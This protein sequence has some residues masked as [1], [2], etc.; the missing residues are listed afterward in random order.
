MSPAVCLRDELCARVEERVLV[1]SPAR[2]RAKAGVCR[3][4]SRGGGARRSSC[5]Q[6]APHCSTSTASRRGK[7]PRA[8][9]QVPLKSGGSPVITRPRA[10]TTI[11][12]N[13][14]PMGSIAIWRKKPSPHQPEA[15]VSIRAAMRLRQISAASIIIDFIDSAMSRNTARGARRPERSL[16]GD[17]PRPHREPLAASGSMEMTASAPAKALEHLAVS[18]SS[19]SGRGLIRTPGNG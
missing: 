15:A 1:D 18:R 3:R 19:C 6:F 14:A 11:D 17:A 10:T 16:E 4:F 12:V 2:A 5:T 8:G 9:A 7:S 13:T